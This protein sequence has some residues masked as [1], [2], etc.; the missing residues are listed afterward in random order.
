MEEPPSLPPPV[1]SVEPVGPRQPSMSLFA[2]LLNVF[3]VPG[4]VFDDVKAS[5]PSI[6]NWLAPAFLYLVVGVVGALLISS[7]PAVQQQ[8][9]DMQ[10]R[11]IQKMVDKGMLSKEQAERQQAGSAV[12]AKVGAVLTPAF[13]AFAGPVIW[14]LIIWLLGA[15]L[16]RAKFDFIKA[17]E[18][19]GLANAIAILGEIVHTLLVVG[20]GDM[21]ASASPTLLMKN[22]DPQKPSFALAAV[23]NITTIWLLAVRSIG[24]ARLAGVPFVRAAWWIFGIWIVWMAVIVGVAQLFRSLFGF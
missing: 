11:M 23:F 17:L 10:D 24:L 19:A 15:K 3:A 14:A 6:A 4:E 12:G 20:L 16:L 7:Q 9:R 18:V 21:F 2:R 1:E 22:A 13:T 5:V 8:I